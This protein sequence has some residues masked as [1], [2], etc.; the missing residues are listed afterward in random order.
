M[1]GSTLPRSHRLVASSSFP[2]P[3]ADPPIGTPSGSALRR[4][5]LH[6]TATALPSSFLLFSTNSRPPSRIVIRSSSSSVERWRGGDGCG[7]VG[8]MGA[9]AWGRWLRWHG[10]DGD[11]GSSPSVLLSLANNALVLV[12][13]AVFIS[14][15]ATP[16]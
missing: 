15:D 10:G 11:H 12:P 13:G 2:M 3:R 1:L 5:L 16:V 9:A 14:V 7:I 8:E 4:G 6:L